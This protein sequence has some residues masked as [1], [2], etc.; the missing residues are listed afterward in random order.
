MFSPVAVDASDQELLDACLGLD[1]LSRTGGAAA[2]NRCGAQILDLPEP[3]LWSQVNT[4]LVL[5]KRSA[6]LLVAPPGPS[7]SLGPRNNEAKYNKGQTQLVG[8]VDVSAFAQG[9]SGWIKRL[10][11]SWGC[12]SRPSDTDWPR[13]AQSRPTSRTCPTGASSWRSYYGTGAIPT[14]P[15]S[16]LP[17]FSLSSLVCVWLSTCLSCHTWSCHTW[18][19][20][21]GKK[22]MGDYLLVYSSFKNW[23]RNK[24]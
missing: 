24:R 23:T 21:S 4:S 7:A 13:G 8:V 16:W 11:T 20:H 6:P 18:S 17:S 10:A 1:G 22:R 19:F 2:L 5:A 14:W 9:G 12:A 15:S 3:R